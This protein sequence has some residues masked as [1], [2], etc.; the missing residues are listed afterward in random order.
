MG[1]GVWL[2]L[3]ESSALMH[4]VLQW[5]MQAGDTCSW[6]GALL[7][8]G[9]YYCTVFCS[10]AFDGAAL[11]CC[12]CVLAEKAVFEFWLPPLFV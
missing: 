1:E 3:R 9:F 10:E 7:V 11:W 6:L 4:T 2:L 5:H 8:K 12:M